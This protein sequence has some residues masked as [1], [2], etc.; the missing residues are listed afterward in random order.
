MKNII[1][2]AAAA[3]IV[4]ATANAFAHEGHDDTSAF[5]G[6]AGPANAPLTVSA[7][8]I[9]NL[10]VQTK[11][12]ALMPLPE[13]LSMPATVALIP[14]KQA[15][16]TTRFNGLVKNIAVQLGQEVAKG[17]ELVTVE[18][19]AFGGQP[20]TL[21]SPISGK[22]IQQNAVVGQP[23][24]FET[25]LMEVA[26]M[27]EVLVKGALYETPHLAHL[28]TGQKATAQIGIYEGRLF[29]GAVQKIDAGPSQDSRALHVYALFRNEDGALRPNLRGTLSVE[30]HE[31]DAPTVVIPESAV[32]ENNG[33]SFVFVRDGNLFE[34]REVQV[35]RRSPPA[36]EIISGVLPEEQ[37]VTQ[38]NYQLQY[39]KAEAPP[40]KP[41]AKDG[42]H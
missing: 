5:T 37:V 16:I 13:V 9:A 27:S 25:V 42:E 20:V 10:G 2:T 3:A 36:V 28:K 18:P 1:R 38:G 35:G 8:S 24:T 41:A 33:V 39:L 34:R 15:F 31:N 29:E 40:A 21:R 12:A 4:L 23:V 22:V 7:A 6:G 19:V 30:L 26:D 17:D 32:L 11:T 14:E